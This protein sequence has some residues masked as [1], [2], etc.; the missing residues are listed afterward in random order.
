MSGDR[1]ECLC[2]IMLAVAVAVI[3][4]AGN[5]LWQQSSAGVET[6]SPEQAAPVVGREGSWYCVSGQGVQQKVCQRSTDDDCSSTAYDCGAK[7]C[8]YDCE[9]EDE[10]RSG[11]KNSV[12]RRTEDCTNA[13]EEACFEHIYSH[14]CYCTS[15]YG[16]FSRYCGTY[17]PTRS[18]CAL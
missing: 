9:Y 12:L 18:G 1:R 16:T 15:Q 5:A 13:E 10:V 14:Y 6:L 8:G 11:G 17:Q 4:F 3:P 2:G 7:F